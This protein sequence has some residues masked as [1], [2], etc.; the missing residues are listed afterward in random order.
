M[1][2]FGVTRGIEV[3]KRC[4]WRVA[5]GKYHVLRFTFNVLCLLLLVA[6]RAENATWNRIQ[7]TGVLRV[8][9]DPTYPPF[10]VVDDGGLRGLDVDLAQAIGTDLGL[11][12]EFVY[13]GYDG[14]YDA[15]ATE[16]VD[17][18]IS[19]LVVAPERTRDFAYSEPYFNVGEIL[20]VPQ[21]ETGIAGMGDLNGR[22][23]AVELGAL[24][25]VEA[26]TWANRLADLTIFPLGSAAE[27]VTAV[28]DSQA[29][30]ALIDAISGYLALREHTNLKPLPDPV[31]VEP[32]AFVVRIDDELLLENLNTSL[33][34]LGRSGQLQNIIG[35]WLD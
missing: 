17:V 6:C 35:Q 11:G 33:E 1:M 25:H 29:D 10:E 32:F 8:G 26:N 16:Q 28:A 24:G 34:N 22:I 15:L 4:E 30:A 2:R 23:L 3:T 18:L 14:L 21:S 31:T 7:Q 12:V 13:F 20:I 27:A 9:L 5:S 19:A